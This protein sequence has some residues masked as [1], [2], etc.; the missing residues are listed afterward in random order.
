VVKRSNRF[1]PHEMA[2]KEIAGLSGRAGRRRRDR[3]GQ[4][5]GFA[6]QQTARPRRRDGS[7]RRSLAKLV[8]AIGV[9]QLMEEGRS[10]STRRSRCTCLIFIPPTLTRRR[11]RSASC[12][13]IGRAWFAIRRSAA[14]STSS[15]ASLRRRGREPQPYGSVLRPGTHV[16]YSDAGMAVAGYVVEQV[17]GR[18]FVAA[19]QGAVLDPMELSHSTFT[20]D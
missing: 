20:P 18:P 4:R 17:T 11:S 13:L 5:F 12:C 19:I 2:D 9:M 6:I 10:R 15:H 3:L 16:K 14:I 1:I 7:T 8:T